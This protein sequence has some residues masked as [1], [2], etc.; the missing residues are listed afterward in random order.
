MS[1]YSIVEFYPD[2]RDN[3]SKPTA[4]VPNNWINVRK[5]F[6]YWPK[7]ITTAAVKK[8]IAPKENWSI[9][10][11]TRILAEYGEPCEFLL[12]IDL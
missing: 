2:E 6:V 11:Y 3:G 9:H 7:S 10:R 8:A 5:L 12:K 1:K 4:I